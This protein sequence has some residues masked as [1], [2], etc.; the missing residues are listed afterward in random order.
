[1]TTSGSPAL[2]GS[3]L[4]P[5]TLNAD[6]PEPASAAAIVPIRTRLLSTGHNVAVPDMPAI[7]G[8]VASI[9]IVA[10]SVFV[11]PTPFTASHAIVSPLVSPVSFRG[12]HPC[13]DAIPDSASLRFH[14][15]VTSPTY[16]PLSPSLPA[17]SGTM[18]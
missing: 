5:V 18:T 3:L 9:L 15:T 7:A 11:S 14:V 1:M 4:T 6:T 10:D 17:I 2:A 8:G 16:Q 12:S 13:E